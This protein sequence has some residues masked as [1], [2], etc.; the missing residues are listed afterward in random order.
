MSAQTDP[1]GAETKILLRYAELAAAGEK[2]VLEV[3]CGD[4]RLT[5][6]YAHRAGHVLGIDLHEDDLRVAVIDRPAD[7]SRRV[8]FAVAD[9]V[10]LP[11]R[12]DAF[13]LAIFAWSF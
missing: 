7:L 2:R 6:R 5:W 3:G 13:D 8:G 9:A 10:R 11:V 4:G 1:E 12:H